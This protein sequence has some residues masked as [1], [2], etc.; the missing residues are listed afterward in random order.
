MTVKP[1]K[2]LVN[3]KEN[4]DS[5]RYKT[6]NSQRNYSEG[7]VSIEKI[8]LLNKALNS[9]SER[10]YDMIFFK[11]V[12]LIDDSAG[13]YGQ[14]GTENNPVNFKIEDEISKRLLLIEQEKCRNI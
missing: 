12:E 3:N 6:C 8:L 5:V 9:C 1:H 13:K 7:E 14:N 11:I 2:K 10:F 4:K